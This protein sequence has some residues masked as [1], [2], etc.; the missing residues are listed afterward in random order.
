MAGKGKVSLQPQ[1]VKAYMNRRIPTSSRWKRLLHLTA[2]FG[3]CSVCCYFM[4]F[5]HYLSLC[6]ILFSS[7]YHCLGVMYVRNLAKEFTQ[8]VRWCL[9]VSWLCVWVCVHWICLEFL[10]GYEACAFPLVKWLMAILGELDEA[11]HHSWNK[12]WEK[13]KGT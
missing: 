6:N 12:D 13:R 5:Q 4:Y 8:T 11:L 2:S 10:C 9:S 3:K 7:A 1:M